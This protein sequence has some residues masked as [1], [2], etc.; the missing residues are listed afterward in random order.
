MNSEVLP[1]VSIIFSFF[2]F[3]FSCVS[4]IFFL[5]KQFSSHKIEWKP[6]P[7]P[8]K[9]DMLYPDTEEV[10][11]IRSKFFKKHKAEE[12]KEDKDDLVDLN[13]PNVMSNNW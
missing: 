6:M 11:E 2:S 3:L 9:D 13:D 5:S 8:D 12:V 1:I 7:A 4:L 10:N